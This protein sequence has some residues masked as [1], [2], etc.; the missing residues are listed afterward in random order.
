MNQEDTRIIFN[1]IEELAIFAE[2]LCDKLE[3]AIGAGDTDDC[4]GALFLGMV[5][6]SSPGHLEQSR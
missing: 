5:T 4:V 1:N 6:C 3:K 2:S